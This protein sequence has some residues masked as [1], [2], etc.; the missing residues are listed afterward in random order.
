MMRLICHV[1]NNLFCI[2]I[3]KKKTSCISKANSVDNDL[4]PRPEAIDI[5]VYAVCQIHFGI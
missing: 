5:W 3:V 4:T 2:I 1:W